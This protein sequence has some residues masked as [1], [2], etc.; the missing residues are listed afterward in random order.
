MQYS[1]KTAF[2]GMRFPVELLERLDK[3]CR[4]FHLTRTMAV[5]TIFEMSLFTPDEIKERVR[6]EN[7]L[8]VWFKLGMP[9]DKDPKSTWNPDHPHYKS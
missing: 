8:R 4:D 9:E 6:K 3:Q 1:G 7:A 2:I 5:R